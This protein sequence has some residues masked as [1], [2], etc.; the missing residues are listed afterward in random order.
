MKNNLKVCLLLVVLLTA[1]TNVFSA[2]KGPWQQLDQK[3]VAITGTRY[4]YPV[5]YLSFGLDL[6]ALK[7]QFTTVTGKVNGKTTVSIPAPDGSW[8]EFQISEAE[9]M[10]PLLAKKY[11]QISTYQGICTTDKSVSARF[12]FTQFGFHAMVM[13]PG[14]TFFI[15]PYSLTDT[16]LYLVYFKRDFATDKEFHCLVDNDDHA[17]VPVASRSNGTDLRTYRLAM[18]CTGEYAAFYGGTVPGALAGIVTSVN[19]VTGVYEREFSIRMVLVPNTDTLIFTNP[20]TDPYT[21]NNGSTMLGQN[22]TTVMARIGGPNF[23]IGHVFSTGGGGIAGLGVVCY[24]S[25]KAMGVTGLNAPVGDPFD[26]DYVAHEMGHQFGGNHTFNCETGSCSGNRSGNAAYEPGSGSTIM[27]YAGICSGNNLQN[28]SDDYFHSKSFDE[29]MTYTT[30]GIGSNCP[31][32]TAT[33]NTPPTINPGG[34]YTIPYL[35]P[36]RLTGSASDPDGDTLTYCWEEYD[37]GPGGSWSAPINNA[38]IFRSFNPTTDP[39][40]LFPKLS[41]ILNNTQ[42]IGEVKPSYA[43]VLHFKL[44]VRDNRL[45]GGGV[46]NNDTLVAVNVINTGQPFAITSPNTTGI[47]WAAGGTETVTWD[48]GG[49]DLAPISTPTVNILLSTDGG[50]TFPTILASGVPNN[51]TAQVPVPVTITATAR[52]MVEGNGNIFFDINDKNFSIGTV[53]ISEYESS[54]NW[55][56]GPNPAADQV[57]FEILDPLILNRSGL[58]AQV[59]DV[60]GRLILSA[61]INDSKTIIR[62][63]KLSKGIYF[64]RIADNQNGRYATIRFVKN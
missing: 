3:R 19:R 2:G 26:I 42:T 47:T 35:T 58:T 11:P 27:A 34:N 10:H 30:T 32:I 61:P 13:A 36:F 14:R 38:P 12:D 56:I 18:A 59:M 63:D 1:G 48:V 21:N 29:V 53:G 22:Q 46:T 37:L 20:N 6:P 23:D 16:G 45:N 41:N 57:T 39:V 7:S 17:D 31:V 28:H 44:T 8:M 24:Y 49:S 15:D 55:S 54:N 43:R 33:G 25:Q 40:R 51:G 60:S 9:V 52:V 64:A 4:I 62:V 50:L 5:K